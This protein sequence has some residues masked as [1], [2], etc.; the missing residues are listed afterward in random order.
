MTQP[1][2]PLVSSDASAA[3]DAEAI[4]HFKEALAGG[5]HWYLALLG[6]MGLWSSAGEV[7]NERAFRYLI[8][9]EAFDWLLLAERL[10][11]TADTLLPEK[12]KEALLFQG[13]PPLALST[14]EVK[15]LIGEKKYGQ[16]LNYFY[17]VTVEDALAMAVHEEIEKERGA[18]GLHSKIVP[19]DE[20]Y[21]RIYD[22]PKEA[23]LAEFRQEK[24]YPDLKSATLAELNEFNYWLFKYR[25][26]RCE[27][28]RIAS[29]TKKALGYLI[30]HWQK[31]GVCRVL[32]ADFAPALNG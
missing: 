1:K 5:Q 20:P 4:R 17:G 2:N 18:V 25:L 21:L 19:A 14:S 22:A 13:I 12:E 23:L 29:D 28:A 3:G 32:A 11:E 31:K 7:Y 6:A 26:K 8:D 16:Y 9:G 15:Q 10:C 24:G 27:K 30:K